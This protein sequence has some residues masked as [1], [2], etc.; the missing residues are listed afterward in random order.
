MPLFS[1]SRFCAPK[2][3][4]DT[5]IDAIAGSDIRSTIHWEPNL[6]KEKDGRA[7]LSFFTADYPGTWS[8]SF[9]CADINGGIGALRQKIKIK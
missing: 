6:I 5:T 1:P 2:Y 9:E 3:V 8:I 4:G 7:T